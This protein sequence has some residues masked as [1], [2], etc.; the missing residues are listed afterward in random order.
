MEPDLLQVLVVPAG[1]PA[2]P[3]TYDLTD[4]HPFERICGGVPLP[5]DLRV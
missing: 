2:T 1:Q 5:A 4:D 3:Q